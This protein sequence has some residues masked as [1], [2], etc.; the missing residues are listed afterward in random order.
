MLLGSLGY[1]LALPGTSIGGVTF[2]VHTLLVASMLLQFGFQSAAFAVLTTTYAIKQRFRPSTP[3][4]EKFF[5]LFTLER[6]VIA[7]LLA[8]AAGAAAI[9][10]ALIGWYEVDFGPLDYPSTMRLVIPGAT[11]VT[12]G[13]AA[14]LNSFLCSMLGLDRR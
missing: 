9:M 2:D 8:I 4:I 7:G 5:H 11:L 10:A 6:G 12:L 13:A 14:V 3:R 1:A